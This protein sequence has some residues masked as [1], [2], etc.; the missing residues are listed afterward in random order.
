MKS[1]FS[2]NGVRIEDLKITILPGQ[3]V[4]IEDEQF[5]SSDCL[6]VLCTLGKVEVTSN[7]RHRK[8]KFVNKVNRAAK[9]YKKPIP[10]KATV[11][12][13]EAESMANE[14]AKEAAEEAANKV[15]KSLMPALSALS[16]P[17]PPNPSNLTLSQ[18]Q[19]AIEKALSGRG[20]VAVADTRVPD[21]EEPVYIPRGIVKDDAGSLNVNSESS[22]QDGLDDAISALKALNKK[23]E[24]S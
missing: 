22:K 17:N 19:E 16:A 23:Q 14:A 15:I 21:F 9:K 20:V 5:E 24:K 7:N 3:T 2:K 6:R 11:T 18:V 13:E 10:V 12:V 4:W 1:L 8:R